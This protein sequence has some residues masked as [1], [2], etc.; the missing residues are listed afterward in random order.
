MEK[1]IRDGDWVFLANCHLSLSWMPNLDKMI[2]NL[3]SSQN[4]HP[5]F[6]YVFFVCRHNFSLNIFSVTGIFCNY[7]PYPSQALAEL[8]SYP[9]LSHSHFASRSENDHRTTKG[10]QSPPGAKEYEDS[11]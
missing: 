10:T 5:R 11:C 2:E 1:G 6:R 3:Q 9:R 8:K 4:V 7:L